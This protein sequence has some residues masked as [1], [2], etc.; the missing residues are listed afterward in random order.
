MSEISLSNSELLFYSGLA[1]MA[2]ALIL[3]AICVV[4]FILSG[5]KLKEQ[6]IQEY[7]E[8]LS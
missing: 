3:T 2:I 7:G 5:R 4:A 1:I 8:P 6:L